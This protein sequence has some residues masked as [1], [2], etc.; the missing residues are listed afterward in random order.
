MIVA[1]LLGALAHV[2]EARGVVD[3]AK[4]SVRGILRSSFDVPA[5]QDPVDGIAVRH[6]RVEAAMPV[7]GSPSVV[8]K[9][10]VHNDGSA[11]V[12]DIV[13][14][15]SLRRSD[16]AKS[17]EPTARVQPFTIKIPNVLLA[18][19]SF[20]YEIRLRNV[21]LEAANAP[22]IEVVDARRAAD[23]VF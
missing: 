21:S 14:S 12:T 23:D 17:V 11:N 22:E 13:L 7:D 9:F 3:R 16:T 18:G 20:D 4:P 10:D 15:V 5:K 19:Y 2:A 6:I 8:L 1:A